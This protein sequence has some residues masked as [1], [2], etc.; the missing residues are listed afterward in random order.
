MRARVDAPGNTIVVDLA[1]CVGLAWL[2]GLLA[3]RLRQ[4]VLLGYLLAGVVL[5]PNVLGVVDGQ[6]GLRAISEIGLALLLFLIGLEIDLKR[7]AAM[8]RVLPVATLVQVAGSTAIGV[9]GCLA[10][11]YALGGGR[12][13]ALY[14][15]FG[16][17][18]SSTVI[19]VKVLSDRSELD[20]LPGRLTL[21]I[22]VL[23]DL[24][25]ILFL[26]LLPTLDHPGLVPVLLTFV[27]VG[28]LVG[29][30]LLISRHLLPRLFASIAEIPELVVV[31]SLAWCLAVAALSE[32]LGLSREMGALVAGM[33]ISTYP[34]A[35]DVQ[36]K[37]ASLRDLFVTVF[38]VLLGVGLAR[39]TWP[40]L[41]MG[42]LL[43]ALML[44][45][46]ALTVF[47]T[48]HLLRQ[49][50]RA[51]FL[52]TVGLLPVSEFALVLLSLGVGHGHVT[53]ETA[54]PMFVAFIVLAALT[55][56]A[57]P[58][59]DR[60]F[61]RVRPWLDR[62]GLRDQAEEARGESAE[63][64]GSDIFVLGLFREGSSF[65]EEVTRHAPS[66]LPRMTVIDFN[67]NTYHALRGRPV[68]TLYGDISQRATLVRAGLPGAKLILCPLTNAVL[69]GI[70]AE[71]L[72]RNLRELNP[73]A[74]ILSVAET[75]ADLV[76]QRAAGASHV[77]LPRLQTGAELLAAVQAA[78]NRLLDQLRAVQDDQL[79]GRAEVVP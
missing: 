75:E 69:R 71:R 9:A 76:A 31:G 79:A 16:L 66:L 26:G 56:Y 13:D 77:L 11:G 38:F 10:A 3:S 70:T 18:L 30:A 21:G 64:G 58:Q 24:A 23:Q 63:L 36:A 72:V 28:V 12:W 46:R 15:G 52:A 35:L 7:V 37:V 34:Y 45:S 68:R 29:A 43:V 67:P 50:R 55:S 4:P 47:P 57:M 65:L 54:G 32:A 6:G 73:G 51:A 19:V 8:G 61:E 78:E 39:P 59:V 42:L 60:L 49:G 33:A 40:V 53:E 27:K 5:G 74:V 17:A 14:L 20:T 2:F 22:T 48:L 62:T 1:L 41:G 25:A 44:A